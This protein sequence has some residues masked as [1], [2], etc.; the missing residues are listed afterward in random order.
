MSS[1]LIKS[2]NKKFY[3]TKFGAKLCVLQVI[4][5]NNG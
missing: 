4:L 1:I 3:S 2:D 5:K